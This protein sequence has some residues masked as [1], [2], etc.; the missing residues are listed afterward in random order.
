MK[1]V[2]AI[3]NL[4]PKNG[5]KNKQINAVDKDAYNCVSQT[6]LKEVSEKESQQGPLEHPQPQ[7]CLQKPDHELTE[8]SPEKNRKKVEIVLL[9]LDKSEFKEPNFRVRR[10]LQSSNIKQRVTT[11]R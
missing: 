3:C 9:I 10:V 11:Q 5:L 6:K 2:G 7:V 1:Q 4:K 8:E